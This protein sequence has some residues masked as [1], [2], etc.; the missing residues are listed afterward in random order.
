MSM[1]PNSLAMRLLENL[2]SFQI[3]DHKFD[4]FLEKSHK[5]WIVEFTVMSAE[6]TIEHPKIKIFLG[7]CP[8]P[9]GKHLGR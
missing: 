9:L 6:A 5:Y 2:Y 7:A 4:T 8:N 3:N 1:P